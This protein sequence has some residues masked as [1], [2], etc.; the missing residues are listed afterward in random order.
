MPRYFFHILDGTAAVDHVGLV[1]PSEDEARSE[2][3][4]GAGEMLNDQ[5][6]TLWLGDTWSMSVAS[7]D[8]RIL[9]TIK[10]SIDFPKRPLPN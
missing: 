7:E 9:F 8:A 5:E 2:A 4:R 3:L 10:F 6:M 1:F